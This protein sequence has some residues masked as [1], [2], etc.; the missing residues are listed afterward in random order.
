MIW[1]V[2]LLWSL[3]GIGLRCEPTDWER[4]W[5]W[6]PL[7]Q[8]KCAR[9]DLNRRGAERFSAGRAG[10]ARQF[11]D[12]AAMGRPTM[13]YASAVRPVSHIRVFCGG[14]GNRF[15]AKKGVPAFFPS[16]PLPSLRSMRLTPGHTSTF[17]SFSNTVTSAEWSSSPPALALKH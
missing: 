8:A 13:R 1:A 12:S 3:P 16:L 9:E 7:A 15:F 17:A 6:F 11:L 2:R 4:F 10:R 14:R 5:A